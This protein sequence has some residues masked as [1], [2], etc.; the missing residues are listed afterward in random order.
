MYFDDLSAYVYGGREELRQVQNVGWLDA[1]H[2]YPKGS[3]PRSVLERLKDLAVH[4][5]VNQTRGFHYCD[6]CDAE[7]VRLARG[8]RKTLLGSAEL[9]VPSGASGFFASPDLIVHYIEAH[10]YLPP[11]EYL[12]AV[13]ALDLAAWDPPAEIAEALRSKQGRGG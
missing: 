7:D 1:A 2:E 5:S 10:G 12:D 11:R 9:W 6:F 4:K 8:D 13:E 3:T